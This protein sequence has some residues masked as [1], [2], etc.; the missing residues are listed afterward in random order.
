[1]P[2]LTPV[3]WKMSQNY[4]TKQK[5]LHVVEKTICGS[6]IHERWNSNLILI[7]FSKKIDLVTC[8]HYR[9]KQ[10]KTKS[11]NYMPCHRLKSLCKSCWILFISMCAH[12]KTYRWIVIKST[13][14]TFTKHTVSHEVCIQIWYERHKTWKEKHQNIC[15][16]K[17]QQS[18]FMQQ[19]V[20]RKIVD[21][22]N[23]LI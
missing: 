4:A 18:H 6:C 1:M 8:N 23:N 3:Q 17:V 14:N 11:S 12:I 13:V 7:I 15:H 20:T 16:S 9:R 10:I 2:S 22:K 21:T 5:I 19:G